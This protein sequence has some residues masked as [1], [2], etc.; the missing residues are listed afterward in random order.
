MDGST[1]MQFA[2]AEFW[3]ILFGDQKGYS[4]ADNTDRYIVLYWEQNSFF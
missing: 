1:S 4:D 2:A 3:Q